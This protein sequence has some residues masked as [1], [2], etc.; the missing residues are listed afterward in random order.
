M[1]SVLTILYV[2]INIIYNIKI[3]FDVLEQI[4]FFIYTYI[5]IYIIIL[6][7]TKELNIYDC[8]VYIL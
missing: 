2:L 5:Y 3:V 6:K 4:R 7:L 8:I 1:L